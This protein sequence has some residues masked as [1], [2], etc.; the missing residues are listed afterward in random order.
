[1]KIVVLDGYALNPGDLSWDGLSRYGEVTV[2]DRTPADQV[3]ERALGAEILLTNKTAFPA[4]VLEQLPGLRYIGVLATGF[5]IVDTEAAKRLDISV[6]NVPAYSTDSVAQL[7]FALLLEVASRVGLHDEA[8][9]NGEWVGSTDFS[10][11]KAPLMELAGKTI[12][13]VGFGSTGRKVSEIARAF[14]MRVLASTSGRRSYPETEGVSFVSLNELFEQAD[15][16]SLH[17]PLTPETKDLV[18]RDSLARMK[19]GAILINT[20][21]GPVVN[22]ADLAD[23]LNRGHLLGAGVDV[24]STEPPQADNPLLNA[25][26]CVITPHIAWAT[27]EARIRLMQIT[28]NNVGAYLQGTP[29]HVVNA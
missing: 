28:T 26:N 4:S 20:A 1:M 11:T 6:T 19:P 2:Y 27:K 8:V 22:E 21:R 3:I 9:H 12:G 25:R 7:V 13:L 29:V 14:G 10:F 24:L 17:C 23:A 18:N 5:N 15:I 16:V